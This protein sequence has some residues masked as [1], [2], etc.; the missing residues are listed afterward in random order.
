M[1]IFFLLG[2]V[3]GIFVASG[4]ILYIYSIYK[5]KTLPSRMTWAILSGLSIIIFLSNNELEA[6]NTLFALLINAIGST[7]V[8]IFSLKFG[9]GGW[10]KNDK[11]AFFGLTISIL[12]WFLVENYLFSLLLA[13]TFDFWGLYPTIRKV[14]KLPET[15]EIVPWFVSVTGALLNVLSLN[16]LDVNKLEFET[17]VSPIYFFIINSIVLYYIVKPKLNIRFN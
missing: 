15:E 3:A 5:G 14:Q 1:S 8:F 6:T 7:I 12:L 10:E 16:L 13:L 11:V 2:L 17:A 4:F 9:V